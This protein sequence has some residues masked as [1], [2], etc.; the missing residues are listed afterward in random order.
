[1]YLFVFQNRNTI[2]IKYLSGKQKFLDIC[3]IRDMNRSVKLGPFGKI[4][5]LILFAESGN[6][7]LDVSIFLLRLSNLTTNIRVCA[8]S[9]ASLFSNSCWHYAIRFSQIMNNDLRQPC[10]ITFLDVSWTLTCQCIIR[11]IYIFSDIP[12][13]ECFLNSRLRTAV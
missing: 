3:Q 4:G 8:F 6:T 12:Q 7:P 1:M 9:E 2:L 10:Y 13:N 5:N 11:K